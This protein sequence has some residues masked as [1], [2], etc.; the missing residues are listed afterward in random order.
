MSI[1]IKF[2]NPGRYFPPN[3]F[4]IIMCN[5]F[6]H[7]TS[8][9]IFHLLAYC[10]TF[11]CPV[12]VFLSVCLL[13][14]PA[15]EF[16]DEHNQRPHDV[17]LLGAETHRLYRPNPLRQ[18]LLWLLCLP[19]LLTQQQKRQ[20]LQRPS[21]TTCSNVLSPPF[22]KLSWRQSMALGPLIPHRQDPKQRPRRS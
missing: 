21:T 14:A 16:S 11:P 7:T 3:S 18:Q 12:F 17:H 6:L 4:I 5:V 15:Q 19:W 9:V 10:T 22:P 20:V 13:L 1:I 8:A 2:Y